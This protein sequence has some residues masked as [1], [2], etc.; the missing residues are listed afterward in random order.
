MTTNLTH[1]QERGRL[2]AL[3]TFL[4]IAGTVI[5]TATQIN[6]ATYY[7]DYVGGSHGNAGTKSAPWKVVPGMPGF[8]GTYVHQAGDVFVFKGGVVWPVQAMPLTILNSGSPDNPDVYTTD[9]TW[10]SGGSWSQPVFDGGNTT[11]LVD[12]NGKSYLTVNDIAFKKAGLPSVLDSMKA[13]EFHNG[14]HLTVTNNTFQ[15]YSWIALYITGYSGT[16]LSNIVIQRNDISAA[17]QGIVVATA[18]PNTIF[19]LVDISG[20][21]IHDFTSK[22][23]GGV[24]GDGI[25][26]WGKSGDPSQFIRNGRIYNNRFYGSFRPSFSGGGSMTALIYLENIYA[27]YLIYNNIMSYTDPP[28]STLF[29][30]LIWLKGGDAGNTA[31]SMIYNNSLWGT[32][33]GMSAGILLTTSPNSA[34]KNNI[35]SGMKYCYDVSSNSITNTT[36]DYNDVDGADFSSPAGKWGTT[37]YSFSGWQGLGN[38]VHGT[39]ANPVFLNAPQDL[40]LNGSSPVQGLNLSSVFQ[41]DASGAPRPP[42]GSWTLGA[43]EK[44]TTN[45]VVPDPPTNLQAF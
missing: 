6:A 19:D 12:S 9:R 29:G 15:T 34:I 32:N 41:I 21:R 24:H 13:V 38:D 2:H 16:T 42:T 30:A 23:G 17:A 18:A 1:S 14:H 37:F 36:V 5:A 8:V 25:H 10:F 4:L 40:R 11:G 35:L 44:N 39:S 33:P 31:G 22:I 3:L 28:Q 43:Y 27:S 20:N 45:V 26:L 7:I